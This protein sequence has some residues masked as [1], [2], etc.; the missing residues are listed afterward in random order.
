MQA[1]KITFLL[2]ILSVSLAAQQ[3]YS[4]FVTLI[5]KGPDYN[6]VYY[7]NKIFMNVDAS[8]NAELTANLK[9]GPKS[10]PGDYIAFSGTISGSLAGDELSISGPLNE[11]MQDGKNYSEESVN[12][13]VSGMKQE[14]AITGTFYMRFDG[15][16]ESIMTF[17]LK[18]GE[19][20]PEL[21][22][23]L[24]NSP[25][26]FDKGWKFGAG[27]ISNEGKDLSE[28]IQWSG[29]AT[30]KPNKGPVSS[31]VF[32]NTGP[33]KIKLSVTDE[34]GNKYEKEYDIQVVAASNYAH[35][36]CYSICRADSHGCPGC[37]HTTAGFI[38]GSASEV[39]I[40]GLPV[41]LVGDNGRTSLCCG[42]NTFDLTEGDPDVLI[43][44]DQ[45]VPIGANTTHCGGIGKVSKNI[46]KLGQVLNANDSVYFI[47]PWGK[48]KSVTEG[49]YE[50]LGTSYLGTTYIVGN[51][52]IMT[53]SLLP[54][55]LI[56]AGPN[57]QLTVLSDE[58]G[59]MTIQV[60]QGSIFFDGHSTGTGKVVIKLKD[61][62]L[63]L[64]GTRFSL[65]VDRDQMK[66]DLLEGA[67]DFR[68]NTGEIIG[69]NA[70][71]SIVSDYR[72]IISRGDA[73]T[74]Q[75]NHFWNETA[76]VTAGTKIIEV[77]EQ[78][79][80]PDKWWSKYLTLK[81]LLI[82]GGILIL[83]I[84]IILLIIFRRRKKLKNKINNLPPLPPVQVNV[85]IPVS[86]MRADIPKIKFC[87][88]CGNQL[89]SGVKFC[90]K[91][92]YRIQ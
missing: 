3:Q 22:F 5:P 13:R 63:E 51:K 28:N 38:T 20:V 34:N 65:N 52:G 68:L 89:L 85:S 70:G 42:A 18:P 41:A 92:G 25:K 53:L 31:P 71:E 69:I 4:G 43:N 73:D 81:W 66:L 24:G 83:T 27:F 60:D 59:V 57:T 7:T 74:S 11:A 91:C 40:N 46:P 87:P 39:T 50:R 23:P 80:A 29:T 82:T 16:E 32:N 33:N 54:N 12:T 35:T 19:I 9:F 17:T 58:G 79:T 77:S 1:L 90:G 48:K 15:K 84:F 8:G 61:S 62:G 64:K 21:L 37:A 45:V 30:F 26:V 76:H 36:G 78:V 88:F 75:V 44:G 56:T 55:G 72:S 86:D 67:I 49:L 2:T 6:A 47:D 14:N 10:E